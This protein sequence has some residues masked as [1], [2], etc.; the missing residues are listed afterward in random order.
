M[1]RGGI[2]KALVLKARQALLD[3]GEHPSIDAVRIEMGN[4][5]SKTTIHR[6]LREID[7]D[8]PQSSMGNQISE[9]LTDLVSRLA[10]RL[11][12]EADERI[13]N[14]AANHA[15]KA[16]QLEAQI[17]A[18]RQ[19]HDQQT[20]LLAAVQGGLETE[21]AAHAAL[22]EAYA[23]QQIELARLD[24]LQHEQQ[25][26]LQERE[27]E[28]LSLEEKHQH[29]RA[30]LEHYRAAVQSQREQDLH[31]HE[32]QLQSVHAEARQLQQVLAVRQDELLQLNRDN[33]RL[34][35]DWRGLQ[36]E[37]EALRQ[38]HEQA[39]LRTEQL[40]T[41]HTR[42]TVS[43]EQHVAQIK[44]LQQQIAQVNDVM[45]QQAVA[46]QRQ[47]EQRQQQEQRLHVELARLEGQLIILER[48]NPPL[49][50][51]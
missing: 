42:L 4:T 18:L 34:L 13:A 5:G 6:Y 49:P 47:I 41:E 43:F 45:E 38:Q 50:A 22:R 39:C 32:A 12:Q 44:V 21:Q 37:N 1:A 48:S 35:S 40:H 30:A 51:G 23:Q 24:Q 3:R 8:S 2:S 15:Q 19:Q 36:R 16:A 27:R 11:N 46:H 29:A 20:A 9:A 7:E 14:A 33:E 25:L 28:V 26:R 10:E 17:L 31:R